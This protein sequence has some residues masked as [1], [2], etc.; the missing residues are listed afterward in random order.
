[1][2]L[3][4]GS[5]KNSSIYFKV[6]SV[7]LNLGLTLYENRNFKDA[8]IYLFKSLDLKNTYGLTEKELPYLNIAMVYV[9]TKNIQKRE[10]F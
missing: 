8:L 1:L 10:M 4:R 5:N 7:Y 6:S 9:E 3:Y 2:K